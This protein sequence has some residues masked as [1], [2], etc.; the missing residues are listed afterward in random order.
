MWK[1]IN[2]QLKVLKLDNERITKYLQ[3]QI[4]KIQQSMSHKTDFDQPYKQ[5][6]IHIYY[7]YYII[8]YYIIII[9]IIYYYYSDSQKEQTLHKLS[10]ARSN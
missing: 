1:N 8:L 9:I 7:Y 3:K 2:Q 4:P 5:K 6:T 10:K